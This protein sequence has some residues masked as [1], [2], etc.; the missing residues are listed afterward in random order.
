MSLP[1]FAGLFD[2]EGCIHATSYI[3]HKNGK[4]E[5]GICVML[6]NTHL[7]VLEAVQASFGG[8]VRAMKTRPSE[9]QMYRLEWWGEKA[10]RVLELLLGVPEFMIKR[11]QAELGRLM[12]SLKRTERPYRAGGRRAYSEALRDQLSR[13]RAEIKF[14]NKHGTFAAAETK[15]Q[16]SQTA[17][18]VSGSD[19]PHISES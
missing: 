1:Y 8:H 12:R 15:P 6:C 9:R 18:S 16:S 14:L 19:S 7:P 4:R 2:G 11:K 5:F 10:D 13:V 3:A 17:L